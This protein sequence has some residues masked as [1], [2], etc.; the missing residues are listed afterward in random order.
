MYIIYIYLSINQSIN[1]SIYLSIHPS[2]YLSIYL[3]IYPSIYLSIY[4]YIYMNPSSLHAPSAP[5]MVAFQAQCAPRKPPH[6]RHQ[7][8]NDA[9]ARGSGRGGI[10]QIA[11]L[12][13]HLHVHLDWGRGKR[14]WFSYEKYGCVWKYGIFPMK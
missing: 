5:H 14:C 12:E 10:V 1:L 4:I 9:R 6:S 7:V 3:S 2:I 11:D 13:D 8:A